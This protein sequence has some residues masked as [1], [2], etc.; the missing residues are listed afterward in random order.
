MQANLDQETANRQAGDGAV[1]ANLDQEAADRAADVDA[2]ASARS[3][4]DDVLAADLDTLAEV[5][6]QAV[7]GMAGNPSPEAIALCG[8]RLFKTVFT[9]STTYDGD[10][11]TAGEGATG[12]DG[13]DNIC[14]ARARA[15]GLPGTYTAWLSSSVTNA[16]DRVT[17]ASVPYQRT[18]GVQVVDDFADLLDCSDTCLDAPILLTEF[19]AFG[20]IVAWTGTDQTG[21]K[22]YLNQCGDW[23]TSNA[24]AF[25]GDTRETGP[26][27]TGI[28]WWPCDR[29]L[30]LYCVQD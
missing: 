1:Q 2:E 12:L 10:L 29:Q 7:Q 16:R 13:G 25:F 9:T 11:K 27:W 17:Q 23:T 22:G 18:D 8:N 24:G 14:N 15:A 19:G 28:G 4:A 20:S 21:G 3:S 5:L 26:R 30:A 6:C